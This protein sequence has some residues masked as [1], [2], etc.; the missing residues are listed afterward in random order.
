MSYIPFCS[1]NLVDYYKKYMETISL[2]Q[3][4]LRNKN[5]KSYKEF[6]LRLTSTH[7]KPYTTTYNVILK[8]IVIKY[9][10][11]PFK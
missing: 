7:S 2:F 6:F 8:P 3:F 10:S 4:L 11:I 9:N 5:Q 1:W